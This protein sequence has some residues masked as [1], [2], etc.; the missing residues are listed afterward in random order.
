RRRWPGAAGTI[1]GARE[2]SFERYSGSITHLRSQSAAKVLLSAEIQEEL[3]RQGSVED[4]PASPAAFGTWH[5][6][7]Q[8]QYLDIKNRLGDGSVLSRDRMSMAYSVEARVPFL[9]HEL[10]EFCARIP[11]RVKM[12]WLR[13]KHILRRAMESV[14]PPYIVLRKKWALHL[15]WEEWL[16]DDLPPFAAEL[17]S[18]RALRETGYF[19]P[20]NVASILRRHR[21]RRE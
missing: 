1:A 12:K 9:D 3:R 17:L 6:F 11:P 13:E 7:A 2:M 8:M 5:P 10:V 15:P 21:E 16:R 18:D 14:L 20:G 19:D 4:A